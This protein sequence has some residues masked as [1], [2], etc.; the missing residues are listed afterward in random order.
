MPHPYGLT[1]RV[2]SAA[3]PPD[4]GFIGFAIGTDKIS[5]PGMTVVA[6]IA[7]GNR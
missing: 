5:P 3:L 1:Q 7:G 4:S 2:I 6:V